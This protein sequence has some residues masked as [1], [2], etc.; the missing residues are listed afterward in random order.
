M[1]GMSGGS[2]HSKPKDMTPRA[3]RGLREPTALRLNQL[4]DFRNTPGWGGVYSAPITSGEQA[5][6][7]RFSDYVLGDQGSFDYLS[8]MGRGEY[9]N[10]NPWV[11][12]MVRLSGENLMDMY[13]TG[14]LE[15]RALFHRAGQQ[16]L[17]ENS[18]FAQASAELA[19]NFLR[20]VSEANVGIRGQ[21]Y[22]S[23]MGRSLQ[24]N[25]LLAGLM[26][27]NLEAQSVPRLIADLGVQRGMEEFNARRTFLQN[28]LTTAAQV[29][30]PTLGQ[31]TDSYN[32]GIG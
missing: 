8:R 14:D 32:V 1:G 15:R 6:V 4:S 24:A 20:A 21:A 28:M 9:V 10:K 31:K 30:S 11:D 23:D 7:N 5:G 29:S 17:S 13:N 22:E 12:E 16:D 27:A 25:Q 19:G 26:Q 3:Y 2:S 18:P